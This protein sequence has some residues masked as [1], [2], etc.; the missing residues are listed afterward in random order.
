[1]FM[2]KQKLVLNVKTNTFYKELNVLFKL[3]IIVWN[4]RLKI[5]A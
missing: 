4:Y 1:M 3:I 5:N 2:I